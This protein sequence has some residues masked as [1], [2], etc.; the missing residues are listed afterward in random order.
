MIDNSVIKSYEE[1]FSI[2]STGCGLKVSLL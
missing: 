2:W 1:T